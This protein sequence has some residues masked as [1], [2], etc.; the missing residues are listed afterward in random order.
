[1]KKIG[2]FTLNR[3]GALGCIAAWCLF[4]TVASHGADP[5]RAGRSATQSQS[6]ELLPL[7]K[8]REVGRSKSALLAPVSGK[9]SSA[10]AGSSTANLADFKK[11]VAPVLTKTCVVC[12]GPKKAK[13]KFRI[14]TLDADLMQGGDVEWWLEVFDVVS[15]GEMPPE[16]AEVELADG[17]LSKIIEWLGPE[18]QKASKVRHDEGSHSSF[19]RL[20]R[21]EYNYALQ[22]LLGLPFALADRLPPETASE[23]G[24]KNSSEMLQ[25]SAMQFETYRE[26]G[27]KALR[28]ATV[29]GERPK[30]IV[31]RL[32]MQDEKWSAIDNENIGEVHPLN[33]KGKKGGEAISLNKKNHSLK[34]DLSNHLPDEGIMRVTVRAGRSTMSADEYASLRLIFSA[35]TSNNA[36]FSQVISDRDVPVTAFADK[37]QLIHFDIP[38]SEIQRNPFRNNEEKFP[39][40]DEF[41]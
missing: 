26:I 10:A 8:A 36:N 31:Y 18:I 20:A 30:M 6:S 9:E 4:A 28:Q 25:M 33:Q 38:L 39:R 22:D 1:M 40:R 19:R 35:H 2:T 27:L 5:L 12:H 13:G 15:N 32:P 24:F 16:D 3:I 41:L 21:Y 29:R 11:H 14:D 34:L 37:P 17:D 23:D 7:A